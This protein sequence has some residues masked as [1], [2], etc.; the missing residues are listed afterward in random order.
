MNVL[1]VNPTLYGL[2]HGGASRDVLLNKRNLN[3]VMRRG[4]WTHLDNV[5]QYERHGR[6]QW[7]LNQCSEEVIR[8]GRKARG[9]FGARLRG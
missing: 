5:R 8:R 3:E 4:R 7:I 6:V 2:R 9:S 1:K